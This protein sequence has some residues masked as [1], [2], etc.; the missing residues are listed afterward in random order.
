M[1]MV[2]MRALLVLGAFAGM[3]CLIVSVELIAERRWLLSLAGLLATGGLG[4]LL[5]RGNERYWRA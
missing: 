1:G 4:F 3:L 2:L 5:V